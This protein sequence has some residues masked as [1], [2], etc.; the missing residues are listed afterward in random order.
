LLQWTLILAAGPISNL[1][2]A[3]VPVLYYH[4]LAF[5]QL[6]TMESSPVLTAW[7]WVNLFTGIVNLLP[8]KLSRSAFPSSS[9]G[10]KIIEGFYRTEAVYTRL[11]TWKPIVHFANL[12]Q[13][14]DL[15]GASEVLNEQL[16]KN[17]HDLFTLLNSTAIEAVRGNF[18]RTKEF[19]LLGLSLIKDGA[20]IDP[21]LT[22]SNPATNV[23][24]IALVLKNNLAFAML[25]LREQDSEEALHLSRE[26]WMALPWE[27]S[28]LGTYGYALALTGNPSE[29]LKLLRAA[30][31]KQPRYPGYNRMESKRM[32]S[33]ITGLY[34]ELA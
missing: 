34:P 14:A 23:N 9:D 31:K 24:T 6:I 15:R 19:C 21:V 27:P 20:I 25:R 33:E 4:S 30:Q 18:Q 13:L 8:F 16:A 22:A 3:L 26:A 2:L 11:D 12:W 7:L 28:I 29:G 1:V 32:I 17:P 5:T 10:Y